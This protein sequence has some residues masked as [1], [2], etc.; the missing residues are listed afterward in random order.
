MKITSDISNVEKGKWIEISENFTRN[1][2][3]DLSLDGGDRLQISLNSSDI[4]SSDVL[5]YVDDI[6]F[7]KENITGIDT[8]NSTGLLVFPNPAKDFLTISSTGNG[9]VHIYN[10][11]G[12]I[13]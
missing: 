2:T 13:I 10:N 7:E 1:S 8:P 4:S 6:A 12:K 11:M 9:L 3:S 5:L